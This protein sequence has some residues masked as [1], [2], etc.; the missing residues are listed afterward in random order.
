MKDW[1]GEG[2]AGMER[3]GEPHT[4]SKEIRKREI[5]VRNATSTNLDPLLGY[6]HVG[7]EVDDGAPG[8]AGPAAGAGYGGFVGRDDDVEVVVAACWVI[9]T[10][11]GLALGT[12]SVGGKREGCW[13]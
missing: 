2:R 9:S 8:G 7:E 3:E 11:S 6:G 10:G 1:D 4:R 12:L 5:H 13:D